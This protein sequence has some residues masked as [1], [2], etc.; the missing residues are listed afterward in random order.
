[1]VFP[2]EFAQ[3]GSGQAEIAGG[4]QTVPLSVLK[5]FVQ[6][7]RFHQ[8]QQL[9][10]QIMRGLLGGAS[11]EVLADPLGDQLLQPL[12]PGAGLVEQ[13]RGLSLIHI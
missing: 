2:Q 11:G 4:E 9:M 7:Y 10:V 12:A 8:L 5:H 13:Q 3:G 1:M 6:Q